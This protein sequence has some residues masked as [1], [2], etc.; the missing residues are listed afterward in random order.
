MCVVNVMVKEFMTTIS[1]RG[2][3]W[4]AIGLVLFEDVMPR[5]RLTGHL[6]VVLKICRDLNTWVKASCHQE[7]YG[8]KTAKPVSYVRRKP[9]LIESLGKRVLPV[10]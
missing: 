8:M 9:L 3:S 4:N 5:G 6:N 2:L 10:A 7:V 1:S